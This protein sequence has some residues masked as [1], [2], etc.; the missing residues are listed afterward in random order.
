MYSKCPLPKGSACCGQGTAKD[1]QRISSLDDRIVIFCRHIRV[2]VSL[3]IS[4]LFRTYVVNENY[5]FG[6]TNPSTAISTD[7][8]DNTKEYAWLFS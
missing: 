4:N 5:N 7:S 3:A 1:N 2:A 6:I 8:E